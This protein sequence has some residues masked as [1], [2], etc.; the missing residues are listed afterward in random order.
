MKSKNLISHAQDKR[1]I[2]KFIIVGS[3]AFVFNYLLLEMFISNF[4]LGKTVA[5]TI[6]MVISVNLSFLVHDK[7]TYVVDHSTYQ[8]SRKYR[9]LSY[10]MTNSSGSVITIVLFTILAQNLSNLIAL[11]L[12]ALVAM[13]WNF[14]MNLI[15]WKQKGAST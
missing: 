15:I 5:E 7:W 12:A 4:H 3:S 11:A 10:L 8:T 9:Y 6:S 2:A 13:C 1:L 14:I